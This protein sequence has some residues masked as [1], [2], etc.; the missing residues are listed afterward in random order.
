[1]SAI[2]PFETLP[3][4]FNGLAAHYAAPA[5]TEPKPQLIGNIERPLRYRPEPEPII[6]SAGDNGKDDG[7]REPTD[8]MPPDLRRE[9][10]A[11]AWECPPVKSRPHHQPLSPRTPVVGGI[12][13]RVLP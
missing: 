6:W 2:V 1:M 10:T 9:T 12:P 13:L 3:Q 5:A 8:D 4:L 11:E 7:G